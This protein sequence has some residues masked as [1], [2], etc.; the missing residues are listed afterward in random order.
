[1]LSAPRIAIVIE[2]DDWKTIRNEAAVVMLS[3]AQR[4]YLV[5]IIG[6][7]LAPEVPG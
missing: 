1:M 2:I 6:G 3:L 5:A 4:R 7:T